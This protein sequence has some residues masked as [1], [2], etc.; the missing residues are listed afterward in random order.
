MYFGLWS[1]LY[2]RPGKTDHVTVMKCGNHDCMNALPVIISSK[3]TASTGLLRGCSLDYALLL[4]NANKIITM[5]I[6]GLM[7]QPGKIKE[8]GGKKKTAGLQDY[9]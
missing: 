8:K 2:N 3:Q 1:V 5:F 9:L 6:D 4:A 7:G